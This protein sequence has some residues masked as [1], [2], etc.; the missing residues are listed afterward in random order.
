MPGRRWLLV[1]AVVLPL[2][3]CGPTI[4]AARFV[5]A[6]PAPPGHEI[7]L[8]STQAPACAYEE[9]GLIVGKPRSGFTSLQRVLDGMQ[10]RARRM[11]GDAIIGVAPGQNVAAS[12]V[13][14][15]VSISS[16]T[17]LSGT[18]IRFRDRGCTP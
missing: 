2:G 9:L 3:A 8:Y 12:G 16:Q 17:A 10:E 1:P 11:G 5:H 14:E 4:D 7:R 13:G 18:V 6:E 15:T